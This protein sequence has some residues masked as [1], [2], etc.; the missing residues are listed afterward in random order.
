MRICPAAVSEEKAAEAAPAGVN[1]LAAGG[2]FCGQDFI[3]QKFYISREKKTSVLYLPG[4][5]VYNKT[6]QKE[7]NYNACL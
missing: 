7:H 6:C 4:N 2:E 1:F 5:P 3:L